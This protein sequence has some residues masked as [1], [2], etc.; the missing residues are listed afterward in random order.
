MLGALQPAGALGAGEELVLSLRETVRRV[1]ADLPEPDREV[2][3]SRFGID[4]GGEPR[5]RLR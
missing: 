3:R 2:V 4:D 5:R 1:V